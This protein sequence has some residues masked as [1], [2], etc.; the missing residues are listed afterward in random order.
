MSEGTVHSHESKSRLAKRRNSEPSLPAVSLK[1]PCTQGKRTNRRSHDIDYFLVLPKEILLHLLLYLDV[2]SICSL[3]RTSRLI[4]HKMKLC[5]LYKRYPE[6]SPFPLVRFMGEYLQTQSLYATHLVHGF[7]EFTRPRCMKYP[8]VLQYNLQ[9][10]T[11]VLEDELNR[12]CLKLKLRVECLVK[13]R[14]LRGYESC[15]K[16]CCASARELLYLELLAIR[17]QAVKHNKSFPRSAMSL[18]TFHAVANTLLWPSLQSQSRDR[19]LS[20]LGIFHNRSFRAAGQKLR[21]TLFRVTRS[22]R[23]C[24]HHIYFSQ[25]RSQFTFLVLRPDV[26]LGPVPLP[27]GIKCDLTP[28]LPMYPPPVTV[29]P[30]GPIIIDVE[31]SEDDES[32]PDL[33]I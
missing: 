5:G 24:Y 15:W 11:K 31:S 27:N 25:R 13:N 14:I 16:R 17:I 26:A 2:I 29:Q 21:K 20:I 8:F 33:G 22:L 28:G 19:I 4:N 30:V 9:I 10:M 12:E 23:R 1:S 6:F 7:N 18:A 3:E 32:F